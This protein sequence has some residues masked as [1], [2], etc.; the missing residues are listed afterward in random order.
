MQS[1]GFPYKFKYNKEGNELKRFA[2]FNVV[3]AL[4]VKY[5]LVMV[6]NCRFVESK[7]PRV[8]CVRPRPFNWR[9]RSWPIHGERFGREAQTIKTVPEHV[10]TLA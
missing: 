8:I 6:P 10:H 5:T 9:Y 7:A 1:Q 4:D 3:K 2:G